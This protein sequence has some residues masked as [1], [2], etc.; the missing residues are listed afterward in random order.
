M[1][2]SWTV[3]DIFNCTS[4][5]FLLQILL[6]ALF[7]HFFGI[8]AVARYQEKKV[9]VVK[10]VRDTGGLE[11]PAVT[12]IVKRN[13]TLTGWKTELLVGNNPVEKFCWH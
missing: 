2:S 6:F 12:I 8:P 4:A 5:K 3:K 9:L 13:T 11:A 1:F 10:S 7:L